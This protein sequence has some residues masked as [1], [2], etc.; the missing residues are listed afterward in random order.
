LGGHNHN[1]GWQVVEDDSFELSL[2]Q[3]RDTKAIDS[4]LGPI[5]LGLNRNPLGFP[6]V[7]G[8]PNI[9]LAKTKLHFLGAEIIPSYRLWFRLDEVTKTVHKLFVELTPPD[10]SGFPDDEDDDIPF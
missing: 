6:E 4:A 1:E 2:A 5:E 3:F 9:R 10:L 7:P 8:F